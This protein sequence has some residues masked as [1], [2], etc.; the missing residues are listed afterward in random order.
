MLR[1]GDALLVWI[2]GISFGCTTCFKVAE[3]KSSLRNAT[4]GVSQRSV[5]EAVLFLLYVN[6]ITN[7]VNCIW[8]TFAD[9][10]KL[11]LSYPLNASVPVLQEMMH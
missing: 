2:R 10:F 1:I 7:S 5:L 3:N 8:K 11:Y 6:Y 9:N 4:S